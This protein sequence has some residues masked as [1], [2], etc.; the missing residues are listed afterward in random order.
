[1]KKSIEI[2]AIFIMVS[3]TSCGQNQTPAEKKES[4]VLHW[5]SHDMRRPRPQVM[6]ALT[7]SLPAPAPKAAIILFD[8]KDLSQW[9]NMKNEAPA[10]KVE[11]G[12]MEIVPGTG[13]IQTKKGFGD[14]YLHVEW[15][16]PKPAKDTR[17]DR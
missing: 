1:M 13:A 6:E 14:V 4:A 9:T 12:Y 15:A 3:L 7:Q 16:S 11:N 17:Q 8:G 10:W 2:F 5:K